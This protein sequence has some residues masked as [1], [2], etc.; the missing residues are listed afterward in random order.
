M[1][2]VIFSLGGRM[3][4]IQK[5]LTHPDKVYDIPNGIENTWVSDTVAGN[6]QPIRFV[7]IGRLDKVK[8]LDVLYPAID[9]IKEED[10]AFDFIGPIPKE[11]QHTETRCEYHGKVT[12]ETQ[13]KTILSGADV[14]VLSSW[15]EGM[16]TVILEA[17][18]SG[19]AII[20][21]DVG[22]V[23]DL[24]DDKNGWLIPAGDV[25]VLT[26]TLKKAI[27]TDKEK[28][29][30]LKKQSIP[31]RTETIIVHCATHIMI[32]R[33]IKKRLF[34][35]VEQRLSKAWDVVFNIHE[36]ITATND[37]VHI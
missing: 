19:L 35:L 33:C 20:A 31:R 12:N 13:M 9:Q 32:A 3:S 16:P 7:F 26:A 5:E 18:A 24:V 17:M 29:N 30:A 14:L 37:H 15:S 11:H 27:S 21:T 28:L 2:D 10:F 8:G 25:D 4:D 22:A 6:D 1:A 34:Q 36:Q 23:G